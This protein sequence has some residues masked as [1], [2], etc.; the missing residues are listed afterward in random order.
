MDCPK[1]RPIGDL[2]NIARPDQMTVGKLPFRRASDMSIRIA[3][4][5]ATREMSIDEECGDRSTKISPQ[6]PC[7]P[8]LCILTRFD[9]PET[10]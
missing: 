9:H 3:H 1:I 10:S 4:T 6:G 5:A 2:L 7:Q 8:S